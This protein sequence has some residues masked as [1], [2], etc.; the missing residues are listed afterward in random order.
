MSATE[1]PFQWLHEPE[2]DALGTAL[3]Q[4]G[5]IYR[6]VGGAVRDSLMGREVMDIDIATPSVPTRVMEALR[7]ADIRAL[8]TGLDHG[9]VTA[10]VNGR[11]FEITTL[12]TDLNCDGRHAEVT[13]G[14]SWEEDAK[15]RDFTINALYLDHEGSVYDYVGGLEDIPKHRIRFIGH[16][17]LRIQEDYLRILRYFRFFAT[18][19]NPPAD[20]NALAA[21][22]AHIDGMETL[23]GER[24][25]QEMFKLLGSHN[26]FASITLM[27]KCGVLSFLIGCPVSLRSI[28]ALATVEQAWRLTP[29][30][31]LRLAALLLTTDAP[32]QALQRIELR[33]RLSRA[34]SKLIS[35]LLQASTLP[36]ETFS[37]SEAKKFLRANSDKPNGLL[38]ALRTTLVHAGQRLKLQQLRAFSEQWQPPRFPLT[39]RDLQARGIPEGRLLGTL[40]KQLENDWEESGYTLN[41]AALLKRI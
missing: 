14:T 35:F 18:H 6:F 41:A 32:K 24:I 33:W 15:R 40:L 16:P 1:T 30:A 29:T 17:E 2:L 12:R 39:G 31:V 9:T 23:S 21:I 37:E 28:K 13:F 26:P 22:T 7:R 11:R 3:S 36:L 19:G 20:K 10:L 27:E 8:P 25:H 5:V 38:L 4:H 34:E